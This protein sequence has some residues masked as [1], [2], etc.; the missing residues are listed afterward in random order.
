MN[1]EIKKVS[2]NVV[3][4]IVTTETINPVTKVVTSRQTAIAFTKEQIEAG[5]A[6]GQ[7]IIDRWQDMLDL[8]I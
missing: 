8:L 7:K 4:E 3:V 5:I 1:K 2:D 6:S